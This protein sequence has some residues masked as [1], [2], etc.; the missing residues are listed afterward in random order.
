[1]KQITVIATLAA[2]LLAMGGC[3]ADGM[4]EKGFSLPEGDA[5]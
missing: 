5:E 3:G 4:S 2:R 1:M